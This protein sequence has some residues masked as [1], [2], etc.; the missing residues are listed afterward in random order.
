M[1]HTALPAC[2]RSLEATHLLSALLIHHGDEMEACVETQTGTVEQKCKCLQILDVRFMDH[3]EKGWEITPL[4]H[5][6]TYTRMCGC[7]QSM[8]DLQTALAGGLGQ[9]PRQCWR[10]WVPTEAG[11]AEEGSQHKLNQTRSF[12]IPARR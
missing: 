9:E 10:L 2:S 8:A 12:Y 1:G 4:Q 11:V 3:L 5:T 7:L 6:C